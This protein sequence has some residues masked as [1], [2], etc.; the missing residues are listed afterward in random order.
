MHT[1]RLARRLADKVVRSPNSRLITRMGHTYEYPRPGLTVD[2][3]IVAEPQKAEPAKLLLI[4]RKK[5]PCKDAWAL[6]GGFVDEGETLDHAAARELQEETGLDPKDLPFH[7][8]GAF[9]DPGRDPRGWTV[10]VAYA[11]LIPATLD[12]KGSDDAADAK[13]FRLSDIP[14]LAFDHKLVVRTALE[15]LLGQDTVKSK[16]LQ[17]QLK[18]GIESLAGPWTPPKE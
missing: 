2:A 8:V 15:S 12:V 10:S 3:I 9:G 17:S 7:Q 4:Q 16:D 11:A 1:C 18:T 5:P 14:P 6:P 13:W